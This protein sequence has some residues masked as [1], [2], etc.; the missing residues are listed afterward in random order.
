MNEKELI[1]KNLQRP[2]V[3]LEVKKATWPNIIKLFT[4][5]EKILASEEIINP[6]H[7]AKCHKHFKEL[8][9][10]VKPEILCDNITYSLPK[11]I[12]LYSN[13]QFKI[14]KQ[15]KKINFLTLNSYSQKN[16]LEQVNQ[17]IEKEKTQLI[18]L[19]GDEI[20]VEYCNNALKTCLKYETKHQNIVKI[21]NQYLKIKE[22][23]VS[24]KTEEQNFK[25]QGLRSILRL[26]SNSDLS[27]EEFCELY[28]VNITTLKSMMKRGKALDYPLFTQA[29]C[30]FEEKRAESVEIY[31][32][33]AQEVFNYCQKGINYNNQIIK[34]TILDYYCLTL[35]R[36]GMLWHKTSRSGYVKNNWEFPFLNESYESPTVALD[37]FK[38]YQ[39]TVDGIVINQDMI[40]EVYEFL[41][42]NEIPVTFKSLDIA[43]TRYV[44][45]I[46]I[47]PLKNKNLTLVL[48]KA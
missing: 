4:F 40:D 27:F 14:L 34:F 31:S 21:L 9:F 28:Q 30:K 29:K 48:N 16:Y 38:S 25:E 7:I 22:K 15:D 24:L 32:A 42:Q 8:L 12:Q 43:L 18:M 45:G 36:P 41:A 37:V 33:I 44:R 26:I 6:K 3:S 13:I 2:K 23:I 5:Y 11:Y 20:L 19:C 46:P 17:K 1:V 10:N 47:L 39:R 35:E